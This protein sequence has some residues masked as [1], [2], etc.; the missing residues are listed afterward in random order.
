MARH[1]RA[2]RL[3]NRTNRLKLPIQLNPHDYHSLAPGISL[4]YRRCKGAGR[5][6]VRSRNADGSYWIRVIGIADDYEEESEHALGLLRAQNLALATARD[7][8]DAP[9]TKLTV[10]E[11]LDQ[12]ERHLQARK[13]DLRNVSRIRKHLQASTANKLCGLLS[14]GELEAFRDAL[15]TIRAGS[16]VNRICK[17]F[18]ASLNLAA[19]R[20]RRITNQLAW[21]EGLAGLS[22][23]HRARNVILNDDEVLQLI[24][25]AYGRDAAL[26]HLI[27]VLAVSGTRIGQVARLKVDDLQV[28]YGRVMMPLSAKGKDR[29]KRHKQH[30]LPLPPELVDKLAVAAA[31]RSDTAPLLT[32][33]DGSA[34][35]DDNNTNNNSRYRDEVRAV[36][37]AIGLDP[38]RVTVSALRH[39]S[40]VRMLKAGVPIRVVAVHHD[41]SVQMIEQTYSHKIGDHT[42]DLIR[43]AM[44]RNGPPNVVPFRRG[45]AIR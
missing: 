31:G 33:A 9:D 14:E 22:G 43:G 25:A 24:E 34:W 28:D 10:S 6:V 16:T 29:D 26:G 37:V 11:A 36:V 1:P 2:S 19:K 8:S 13:G 45:P 23:T 30:R 39:S 27:E 21:K 17:V 20:D 38:G 42:E 3:A 32:R 15:A 35:I 4:G 12:Y 44:L 40:I 5:W 41:T 7:K 18:R